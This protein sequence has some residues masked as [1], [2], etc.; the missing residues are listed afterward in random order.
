MTEFGIPARKETL[1]ASAY[2]KK[3]VVLAGN[4]DRGP[5]KSHGFVSHR[6]F[7]TRFFL[8]SSHR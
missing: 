7:F 5:P 6:Q 1:T 4:T 8:K 3:R 2:Q